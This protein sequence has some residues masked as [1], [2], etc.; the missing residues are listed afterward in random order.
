MGTTVTSREAVGGV[1]AAGVEGGGDS[2]R[3]VSGEAAVGMGTRQV[4]LASREDTHDDSAEGIGRAH[5]GGGMKL[6]PLPDFSA[7]KLAGHESEA[8]E[9]WLR[10]LMKHAELQHWS[11]REKLLQFE[12]YLVGR[13]ERIYEVLPSESKSSYA[14]ATKALSER[15]KPAGRKT[16]SSA[17]LLRRKQKP[18]ETVD[19]FVQ[20]FENLLE[21]SYGH[22]SGIDLAFKKMLKRDLFVQGL[23]L[24]LQEKVLP[25]AENF[26]EAL[27]QARRAG[28]A[29][30]RDPQVGPAKATPESSPPWSTRES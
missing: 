20:A 6:P 13:A 9:R 29:A 18:G 25:T 12:L 10:K 23:I 4:E 1:E 17:Q 19:E 26:T 21:K 8:Y 2:V 11:E 3:G 14:R 5:T 27:Y 24:K 22:K 30:G 28:E 15:L 16:L 7:D